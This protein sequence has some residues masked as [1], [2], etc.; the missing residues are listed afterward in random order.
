MTLFV[1]HID[2]SWSGQTV[3]AVGGLTATPDAWLKFT[4]AWQRDV[5][6]APPKIPYFKYNN[7][8]QLSDASQA[9]KI[10]AGIRVINDHVARGDS[11]ITEV[12]EYEIYFKGLMGATH[13]KPVHFGYMHT[14][15]QCALHLPDPEGEI[16][17]VF[18]DMDD[19]QYLELL[20]AFRRFKEVCPDANVKRRLVAEPTRGDD[21]QLRPLQAADLWTSV[22]R[23]AAAQ[24]PTAKSYLKQI[25]IPNRGFL[26][27]MENL[28]QLLSKSVQR[29]PAITS[30]RYY[31]DRKSRSRRLKKARRTLK[32]NRRH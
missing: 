26:W 11:C 2:E 4:D 24:D 32:G 8:H 30:G 28:A 16:I 14:I 15:Q 18:D 31:E 21:K 3:L 12:A 7:V 25:E 6:D 29:F 9:K 19:T 22:I 1:A 5:L 10:A 13:D 17:F 27:D 23:A 20:T